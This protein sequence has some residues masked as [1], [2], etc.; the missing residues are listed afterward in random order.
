M[1]EEQPIT[2]AFQQ[3]ELDRETFNYNRYFTVAG[4]DIITRQQYEQSAIS[5]KL[6][7]GMGRR[8]TGAP[9]A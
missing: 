5:Y 6:G 4:Q 1:R 2:P 8:N 9:T 7:I 3:L